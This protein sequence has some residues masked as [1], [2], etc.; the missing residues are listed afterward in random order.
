MR[1]G[2]NGDLSVRRCRH[3]VVLVEVEEG[4]DEIRFVGGTE[5][6]HSFDR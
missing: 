4:F 2:R 6:R 1:K 5:M 3:R